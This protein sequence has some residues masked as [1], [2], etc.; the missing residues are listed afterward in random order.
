MNFIV[1]I[2]LTLL[3]FDLVAGN[4]PQIHGKYQCTRQSL[5]QNEPIY[6]LVI[7]QKINPSNQIESFILH[8]NGRESSFKSN[9]IPMAIPDTPLTRNA[10]AVSN[11]KNHKLLFNTHIDFINAN[12]KKAG[13][14]NA[15]ITYFK[16]SDALVITSISYSIINQ[17]GPV[18]TP[19][20]DICQPVL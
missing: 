5:Q 1:F 10:W 18:V 16:E 3:S 17:K 4:C 12:N 8:K 2:F 15:T 20:K 9:G 13:Y 14:R 11:C 7:T 6:H 19:T